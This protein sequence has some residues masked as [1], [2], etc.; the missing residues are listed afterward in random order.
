MARAKAEINQ[1]LL[2]IDGAALGC[3]FETIKN[4]ARQ[5]REKL[6]LFH[7]RGDIDDETRNTVEASIS[8]IL[9]IVQ[10]QQPAEAEESRFRADRIRTGK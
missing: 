9:H 7:N 8:S 3:D 1:L 5:T 2:R 6:V 4:L 10:N